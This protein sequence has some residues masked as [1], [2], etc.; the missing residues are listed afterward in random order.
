MIT[1]IVLIL[2]IA[3]VLT[4]CGGDGDDVASPGQPTR[5]VVAAF[6]PLAFAT[7]R[8]GGDEVDVRNLTPPGTEPH[9]VELSARDVE[10]VRSADVVVYLGSGFQPALED[11]VEGA[12]GEAVDVLQGLQLVKA[13]EAGHGH[14]E[15]TGE[16][17]A[18]EESE[19]TLDPHVWLDPLRFA[20]TAR[21]I[22][23]TLGRPEGADEL[24]A[25]L[26]ALNDEFEEGLADCER[27]EIVTSHAAF[28]YLAARYGLEQIP[29]TGV[30]PEA[31][32]TAQELEDVVHEVEESGATTVFFETLVSPRLAETIARETGAETAELNPIEG[33]TEDELER[34]ENYLSVMRANLEALGQALGCR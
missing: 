20:R 12:E 8:V 25:E 10:A 19:E 4:A 18:E 31:E 9:D 11:A 13:A 21:R 3:S 1:R 27:H 17:H 24:V 7:E 2:V 32:P 34:G 33:L 6:Y 5:S 15:E 28:A 22:A 29:I 30:S 23:T 16:A 26:E 14:E